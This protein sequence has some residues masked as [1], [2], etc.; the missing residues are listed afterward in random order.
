MFIDL[1]VAYSGR[2]NAKK[3]SRK[4][5]SEKSS[6][7]LKLRAYVSRSPKQGYQWPRKRTYNHKKIN[8]SSIH[9]L[10]LVYLSSDESIS[11]SFIHSPS[12]TAYVWA[13]LH[14]HVSLTGN[15]N[16]IIL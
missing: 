3:L 13:I 5:A 8:K 11:K 16:D 4:H 10:H 1:Y 6:L 9:F 12:V 2:I 14:P 15:G 7:A